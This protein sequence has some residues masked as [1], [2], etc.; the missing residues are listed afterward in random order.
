MAEHIREPRLHQGGAPQTGDRR[1]ERVQF[2][3]ESPGRVMD[4]REPNA[5]DMIDEPRPQRDGFFRIEDLHSRCAP[6]P[7]P[8][9]TLS[10]GLGARQRARWAVSTEMW[11]GVEANLQPA[12][13]C[14]PS[15]RQRAP[16]PPHSTTASIV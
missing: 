14:V 1:A 13:L 16:A 5:A 7:N 11:S 10:W 12:R 9:A 6:R 2:L 3:E 15:P 4:A 8:H